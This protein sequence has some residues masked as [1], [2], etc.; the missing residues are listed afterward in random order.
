MTLPPFAP[1]V[2]PC[3]TE[4][5][6]KPLPFVFESGEDK[7]GCAPGYHSSTGTINWSLRAEKYL[8]IADGRFH[9]PNCPLYGSRPLVHIN[10]NI[11]DEWFSSKEGQSFLDMLSR[12]LKG[13]VHRRFQSSLQIHQWDPHCRTFGGGFLRKACKSAFSTQACMAQISTRSQ[14]T[15]LVCCALSIWY[16]AKPLSGRP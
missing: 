9:D 12:P 10:D 6:N 8:S 11:T 3:W 5:I 7:M 2:K 16:L 15:C 13:V 1:G 4:A 14:P